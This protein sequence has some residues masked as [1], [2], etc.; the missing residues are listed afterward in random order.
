MLCI[1]K[2][3]NCTSSEKDL[4]KKHSSWSQ[5]FCEDSSEP[6]ARNKATRM[7]LPIKLQFYSLNMCPYTV[8]HHP[9]LT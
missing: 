4:K 6:V 5:I 1:H 2:S 9:S 7:P 8:I 3:K